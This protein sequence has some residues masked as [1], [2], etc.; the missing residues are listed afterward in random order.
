MIESNSFVSKY[1]NVP[2]NN[3]SS[4]NTSSR[5]RVLSDEKTFNK[6]YCMIYGAGTR[7]PTAYKR[8]RQNLEPR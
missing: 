8:E 7:R 6:T 3:I 2:A 4:R 1:V 5:R